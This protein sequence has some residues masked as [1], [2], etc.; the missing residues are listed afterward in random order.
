MTARNAL[1]VLAIICLSIRLSVTPLSP[2]TTV[3]V[4]SRNLHCGLSQGLVFN[5]KIL[6]PCVPSEQGHER[7]VPPLKVV[8]WS[9]LAR[10]AWKRLQMGTDMLLIITSTGDGLY[11]FINIDDLVP[12]KLRFL[13]NFCHFWLQHRFQEWIAMKWLEIDQDNLHMKFLA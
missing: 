3:Q 13:V 6:C 5:D 4:G 2:I 8:I 12:E 9:L 1:H 11:R 7:G 10:I